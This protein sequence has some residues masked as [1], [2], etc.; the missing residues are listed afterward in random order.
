[1][2]IYTNGLW[3][4]VHRK[5]RAI[6]MTLRE[7]YSIMN[8]NYEDVVHRLL[9]EDRIRRYLGT[10]LE[11][12]DYR[13]LMEAVKADDLDLIFRYAHN[14]KGMSLNLAFS[15]LAVS[16]SALC[17]NVRDGV[18]RADCAPYMERVTEDYNLVIDA[19]KA[20]LGSL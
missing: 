10:F 4:E 14:L 13:N 7:C 9:K 12:A 20:Y 16:S 5:G 1:M 11:S 18:K 2:P 17:D 15:S 6:T 3:L 19:I 8:G